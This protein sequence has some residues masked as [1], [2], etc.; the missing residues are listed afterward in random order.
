MLL[1]SFAMVGVA[2][3]GG[4]TDALLHIDRYCG[5]NCRY[6]VSP[7]PGLALGGELGASTA[8]LAEAAPPM[9]RGSFFD[10]IVKPREAQWPEIVGDGYLR[11]E[12]VNI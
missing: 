2:S 5:A 1:L 10:L 6:R 12:V 11:I 3:L 9:R 7:V 8:L 4:S